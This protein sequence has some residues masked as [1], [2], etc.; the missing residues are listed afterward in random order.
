MIGDSI[1][2]GT[3]IAKHGDE[4]FASFKQ[5]RGIDPLPGTR[6]RPENVPENRRKVFERQ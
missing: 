5:P 3:M 4:G 2:G 6:N 1:K